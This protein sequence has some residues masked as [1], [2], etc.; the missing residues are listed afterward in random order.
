MAASTVTP[1]KLDKKT[2]E[3]KEIFKKEFG[4]DLTDQQAQEKAT[5]ALNAMRV[6]LKPTQ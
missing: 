2:Q 1:T 4:I 3:F 6:I 5:A